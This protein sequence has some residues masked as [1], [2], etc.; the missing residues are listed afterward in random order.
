MIN[1]NIDRAANKFDLW[2][3]KLLDLTARNS[4]LNLKINGSAVPLLV[5]S[6]GGIEDLIFEEKDYALVSRVKAVR[7]SEDGQQEEAAI[8]AGEYGIEDLAGI[9]EFKDVLEDAISRN[10]IY[11]ALPEKETEEKLKAL[12]RSARTSTEE[13]GA[14]TLFLACGFLKWFDDKKESS[15]FAPVVL[16]PVEIVRKFGLGKYVVRKTDEDTVVNITLLE[17]LRKDFDFITTEL[18]GDIRQDEKGADVAGVLNTLR[19]M[20]ESKKDWEVIDACVLG[21]F[22][23]SQFVMWNDLHNHR[24][25]IANNKI[26][27]SLLD[28]ELHLQYEDMESE[29]SKFTDES[30][31]YLPLTADNSQLYA[32]KCA[33]DGKSFV[34]HG[35]PGTGKSQTITSM[36]A[37]ALADGKKVLFAAEKKAALDVVYTRLGKI[38][39]APFCLELHTNKIRKG[40]VLDQLK[41]SIAVRVSASGDGSYDKALADISA[42]RDYLDSY[43]KE[44]SSVRPCGYSL[45]EMLNIYAQYK[46]APDIILQDDFDEGLTEERINASR[47]ALGELLAAGRGM[48][49]ILP[50]VKA[51]EYSQDTKIKLQSELDSLSSSVDALESALSS[52]KISCPSVSADDLTSCEA[53]ASFIERYFASRRE[54]LTVWE[55]GFLAQDPASLKASYDAAVSKWGPLRSGALKKVYARISSYDKSKNALNDLGKHIDALA[56]YKDEFGSVFNVSSD[57]PS[58]LPEFVAAFKAFDSARA[59]VDSRLDIPALKKGVPNIK[60]EGIRNIISSIRSNESSIRNKTIL[61][62]AAAKCDDLKL[63]SVTAAFESGSLDESTVDPAFMKAWSKLMICTIIDGSEILKTFSG[64]VFDER[65][66]QLRSLSDEFEKITRQ[67]IFLKIASRRP[68]FSIKANAASKLGQL[69]RLIKSRGR[70]VSIRAMFR[71]LEDLILQLTPCVLMSPKSAAQFIALSDKP[72]FDLVVFDEASQLPTAEA[73]GVIARGENAIIVGDPNQMPPTMFFREQNF[74]EENAE[75]EDLES[76]LDDCLAIGMPQTRLLWHYRSRH[77]SLITFSNRSFYESKLYTFPSA[78]NKIS[79]ATLVKCNGVFDSG[80]TRTNEV[81]AKAIVDE[82]IR[83][84]RESTDTCGVVTFNIQ[85]Q[86]LIEDMVDEVCRNDESFEKWAYGGDEPVFIKNLENVQGDERD[87]ILFSVSYGPDPTGK[88]SMNFGPLNKEGGWRRLNVAVTRSRIEMKVFSSLSAESISVNE[89][90]PEGVKALKR[91]LLYTSGSDIWDAD[92]TEVSPSSE[93]SVIIDRGSKYQGLKDDICTELE[94]RGYKTDKNVG[95]SGFK[96]DI[97]VHLPDEDRYCL[98]ILIDGS[99]DS[100]ATSREISQPSMLKGLGWKVI[101]VWSVE[102]WEDRD[103]VIDECIKAINT[104][105]V[106]VPTETPEIEDEAQKKT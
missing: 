61:N 43:Q 42:R 69:Q 18:E 12:Y 62:L 33:K 39:I 98:G 52:V 32:I 13:N 38:G 36:I 106:E 83:R 86:N 44:L 75:Y 5:P 57:I 91:F 48:S 51:T 45:Y 100:S 30:A 96:V 89:A 11:S 41:E 22:S 88:V 79:R 92:L 55:Q 35:P 87:V 7:K 97:G 15:Y 34:L 102:W 46:D 101:R 53:L 27:R 4:L 63:S 49:G 104:S 23:F 99:S 80:K 8:P 73:V 14:G 25:Q 24:E 54:I 29:A 26:V 50:F 59:S 16:V 60:F 9:D 82:L 20:V 103:L 19:G 72:L 37:N 65:V 56:Q 28:G 58:S 6:S 47:A 84:S 10:I 17:K 66:A 94:K 31:A 76:I 40:W 68:D 95:S 78:D 21:M 105:E 93:S 3:R 70:G 67:E 64:K 2:E 90:T 71:D 85:Q 1:D 74:D 81:E 77:E